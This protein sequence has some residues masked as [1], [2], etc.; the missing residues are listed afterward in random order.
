MGV[1]DTRELAVDRAGVLVR[2]ATGVAGEK[3][4]R[5]TDVGVV[6]PG[7]EAGVFG[8]QDTSVLPSPVNGAKRIARLIES[9]GQGLRGR[10]FHAGTSAARNKIIILTFDSTIKP[11]TRRDAMVLTTVVGDAPARPK[12][13]FPIT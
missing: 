9:G 12:R 11:S 6:A 8:N 4:D 5:G 10:S 2:N 13:D 1:E 7:I 3:L